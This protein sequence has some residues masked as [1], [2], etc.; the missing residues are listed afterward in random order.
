M[1]LKAK[2][3]IFLRWF[4]LSGSPA[5]F[6]GI[7]FC[8]WFFLMRGIFFSEHSFFSDA[9]SYYEHIQFYVRNMMQGVFPLW[10]PYS[11][12][13]V[14]NDFYLRR[15][16]PYN[17]FLLLIVLFYKIG[18]P[19]YLAY[20]TYLVLYFFLGMIG[21]FFLS[22]KITANTT[23]ALG[24]FFILTFSA[25]GTRIFDSYMIFIITP[26]FW[27]FYFL[28][29]F[30]SSPRRASFLGIC[31]TSILLLTTYVPFY[32][33]T[34]FLFFIFLYSV[35]YCD[36]LKGHFMAALRFS[37]RNKFFVLLC[38]AAVLASI[39]P[40]LL[41][42]KDASKGHIS[43]PGRHYNTSVQN[44]LAVENQSVHPW[45]LPEEFYF[46][47]YYRDLHRITYA[48][49]YMPFFFFIVLAVSLGMRTT[50]LMVFLILWSMLLALFAS[51]MAVPLYGFL[52]KKLFFIKFFRNLHFILWFALLPIAGIAA[53]EVL[54]SFFAACSARPRRI[55][56]LGV[57]I[58]H[59]GI[60]LLMTRQ[61]DMLFSSYAVLVLSAGLLSSAAWGLI[62][63]KGAFFRWGLLA[64]VM[65]QPVEVFY[66]FDR[67]VDKHLGRTFYDQLDWEFHYTDCVSGE[68]K[69]G[70]AADAP[71]STQGGGLYYATTYYN[72]L[73]NAIPFSL[74]R[75]Y[76]RNKF[77]LYSRI[78]RME[79]DADLK[80]V[81]LALS[82][83]E[84][85]ALVPADY[86][87]ESE[88]F[89]PS[90]K[91]VPVNG[92]SPDFR[93][94]GY[95]VN[96][97]VLKVRLDAPGFLVFNDAF[98][99]LWRATVNGHALRVW[100]ANGAFKGIKVPAGESLVVFRF[101]SSGKYFLNILALIATYGVFIF[102]LLYAR[103]ESRDTG[104][105]NQEVSHV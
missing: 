88:V 33:V 64:A 8:V 45:A 73:R 41:F 14:P 11:S 87:L 25:L 7:A 60:F 98:H 26:L 20:K 65:L 51:P 13:G 22:R 86:P 12:G 85:T 9:I 53:G 49:V 3:R 36:R 28:V 82:G 67:N 56:G 77:V 21:A 1:G 32:F 38:S 92:P 16:G 10:D 47:A 94:L 2:I 93:V 43:I 30:F 27:F 24:T 90:R 71:C 105:F 68:G 55:L 76:E 52:Y 62:D 5:V 100:R 96:H 61:T 95:D 79:N 17:P 44:V 89:S 40:G 37:F 97:V 91:P 66:F 29:S 6:M 18:I 103:Q 75:D 54:R 72:K 39:L 63:T 15:I 4:F 102:L 78:A 84:G 101:A 48:I 81:E 59:A 35:I 83:H 104:A 42:F 70:I 80:R 46:A 69:V 50:R 23:A 57:L 99:P 19:Y 31:F 34:I 58:V 74:I